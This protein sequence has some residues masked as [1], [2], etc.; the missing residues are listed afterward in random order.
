VPAYVPVYLIDPN[1]IPLP[2][3]REVEFIREKASVGVPIMKKK[4][5]EKYY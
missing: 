5:I 3:Y 4:L 1:D 2:Q